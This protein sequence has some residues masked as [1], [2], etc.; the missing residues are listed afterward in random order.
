MT[1][2]ILVL[3]A[4]LAGLFAALTLM[5]FGLLGRTLPGVGWMA[6]GVS[7]ALAAIALRAPWLLA[8]AAGVFAW[9]WWR[10]RQAL[11]QKAR[12]SNHETHARAEAARLLGVGPHANADAINAA[13]RKNMAQAHP[14]Q[15]GDAEHARRLIAARDLLLNRRDHV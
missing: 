6:A 2:N 7:L 12:Q 8:G 9:G 4:L 10:R 5:R 3:L 13:F 14:D 1:V 15:G 11:A